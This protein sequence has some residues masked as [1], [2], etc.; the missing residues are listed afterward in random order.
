MASY[1]CNKGVVLGDKTD[2]RRD[3]NLS[4]DSFTIKDGIVSDF[5]SKQM[6]GFVNETW[7]HVDAIAAALSSMS[8]N[9]NNKEDKPESACHYFENFFSTWA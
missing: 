5:H 8:N 4:G 6:K 7:N 9:D 2:F 1:Y 3:G